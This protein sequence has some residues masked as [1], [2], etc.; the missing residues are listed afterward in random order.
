MQT[1]IQGSDFNSKYF[2]DSEKKVQAVF[3]KAR[4]AAP[5]ILFF[6]E[7]D[8]IAKKRGRFYN[9]IDSYE[10]IKYTCFFCYA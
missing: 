3:Q 7:I 5:C 9:C 6:D 1:F 10:Q 8:A 4:Q 2:G